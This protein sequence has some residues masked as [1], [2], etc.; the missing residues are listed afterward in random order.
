[1]KNIFRNILIGGLSVAMLA[2]CDLTLTPTTA[3][4]YEDGTLVLLNERDVAEFQNGVIASY[5]GLHYGSHWQTVEVMTECFNAT[6]DFGNNYGFVHKLGSSLLASDDNTTGIWQAHYSS[7][8][9]YNIAIEQC[10]MLEDK[11]ASDEEAKALLPS[12]NVLK[13]MALFCRASSYLTLARA[14]SAD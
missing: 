10:V 1:M 13:G 14:F 2:S 8:K 5:R 11:A 7:I 3:I 12:A 4:T 9:N 6:V